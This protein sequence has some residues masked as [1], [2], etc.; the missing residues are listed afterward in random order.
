MNLKVKAV[1]PKNASKIVTWKS[2]NSKIATVSK[3]GV[4]KAK[5]AGTVTIT[6]TSKVAPKVKATCKIKVYKAT[7]TLKLTTKNKYTLEV[8]D[9]KTLKATVT[10]PKKGAQP[11]QWSSENSKIAKVDS[12]GKVTAV[13]AGT[14]NIVAKSGAKTVKTKITVKNI[15]VT[16]LTLNKTSTSIYVGDKLTL[17]VKAVTP[18]NALKDVTWQSSNTKVA[19]VSKDGVVTAKKNGTVKITA[20]SKITKKVKATCE[21]KVY[22]ATKTL[23]LTTKGNYKLEVGETKTLKAK[24][25]NPTSGAQPIKWSSENSKIAKVDSKGKVTAVNAE[26]DSVYESILFSVDGNN[27]KIFY[28]FCYF[29][30]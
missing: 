30:R 13:K 23:K 24:V 22:K 7:K 8:G 6:A 28:V 19:T 21:I 4:V 16:K 15:P 27:G 12:K 1:T 26:A 2:S 9:K 25:T 11:V 18:K 29:Y 14:T 3:D 17:K 20:I 5:K 10:S